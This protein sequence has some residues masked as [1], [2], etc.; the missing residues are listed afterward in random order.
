MKELIVIWALWVAVLLGLKYLLDRASG[1]LIGLREL[2]LAILLP[3]V[4]VLSPNYF[5]FAGIALILLFAAGGDNE[6]RA[7]LYFFALWLL[8]PV[9]FEIWAPAPINKLII[10]RYSMLVGIAALPAVIRLRRNQRWKA[11]SAD[12]LVLLF[13]SMLWFIA[14]RGTSF[15][16]MLREALQVA[17]IGGLPYYIAS[18]STGFARDPANL[19][20]SL[21]YCACA[22]SAVAVFE[23]T[24]RWLIYER[25]DAGLQNLFT[26]NAYAGGRGGFIRPNATFDG[27]TALSLFL[28]LALVMLYAMRRRFTRASGAWA[29]GVLLSAGVLMT[30]SRI[31]LLTVFV[32][33]MATLAFNRK[34]VLAA[35][36]GLGIPLAYEVLAL[37]ASDS[38]V[39]SAA[40]GF[41]EAAAGT[42]QYR[43]T[44]ARRM[45]ELIAQHPLTGIRREQVPIEM[46]DQV[47]GQGIV[48]IVNA[49][50]S[51][52]LHAGI[53][54]L[55]IFLL[56]SL[57]A[58]AGLWRLRSDKD[59][60]RRDFAGLC[61][62]ALL[63]C[64]AALF[65]TNMQGRNGLILFL[66]LGL[67]FGTLHRFRVARVAERAQAVR[68]DGRIV[69]APVC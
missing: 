1:Q 27:P 12:L 25:M 52:G 35:A 33:A 23:V 29:I 63:A 15:T 7:R 22:L 64:N 60:E 36:A 51:A 50:L 19:V 55:M 34:F 21:I 49:P 42:V 65:T 11:A 57:V 5:V 16:N 6:H 46:S 26:M 20:Q 62:S 37:L 4:A 30:F 10:V 68:P 31:G 38:R 47:Q 2:A 54:G 28:S 13:C 32:G 18:R 17:F 69:S 41:G 45:I 39:I 56:P 43:Q 8:P 61:F 3:L 67:S 58:L 66:L 14:A 44:L 24:R 53:P 40:F 48:D 59:H 9:G